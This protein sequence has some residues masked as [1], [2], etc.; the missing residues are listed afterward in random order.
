MGK[1]ICIKC[2]KEKDISEYYF[3]RKKGKYFNTC[4]VCS[5]I[6]CREYN[7]KNRNKVIE[8]LRKYNSENYIKNKEL[9]NK[10]NNEYRKTGSGKLSALKIYRNWRINNKEKLSAQNKL[11]YAIR[12]GKIK[13]LPCS[14]CFETHD[15]CGHHEDYSKPYDVIWLCRSCHGKLHDKRRKNEGV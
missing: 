5:I 11:R 12:V 13:R 2:C 9:I 14:K 4:K 7:I 6:K 10:R 1:K 8:Y 15:V 3:S